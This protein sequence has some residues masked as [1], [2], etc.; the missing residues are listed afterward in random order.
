MS[1]KEWGQAISKNQALAVK[2]FGGAS[3]R[4]IGAAFR[5]IDV[6]GSDDLTW[7][8]V[9]QMCKTRALAS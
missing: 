9:R 7:E 2:Y 8:E 4:E 1:S 6:D 3:M 5:R